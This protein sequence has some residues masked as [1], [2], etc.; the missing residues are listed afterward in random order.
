MLVA[1]KRGSALGNRMQHDDADRLQF[2]PSPSAES[3]IIQQPNLS[4]RTLSLLATEY[5]LAR[6]N[7]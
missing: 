5:Y 3:A 2:G 4:V 6:N 1:K 7:K